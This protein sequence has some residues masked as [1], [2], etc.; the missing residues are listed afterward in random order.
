MQNVLC[1]CAIA[2]IWRRNALKGV[3]HPHRPVFDATVFEDGAHVYGC[4]SAP[5][6]GFDEV[7][8]YSILQNLLPLFFEVILVDDGSTDKTVELVSKSEM[9]ALRVIHNNE[10]LGKGYS[11]RRGVLAASGVYV[12]FADADLSAPIEEVTKLLDVAINDGAD[13]VIGSR[14]VDRRFIEKHQSWFREFGGV[15]FNLAVRALLGLNLRDTQCGF[16]LFHRQNT[17]R[18]FERLTTFGFGFDPEL[19]FLAKRAGLRIREVS[20]RWSHSEGS[21]F[22][23]IRNGSRMFADLVRIRWLAFTGRYP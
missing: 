13:V 20:V 1:I 11:V 2:G 16:K 4:A 18:A 23:P 9:L 21:R 12:L 6:A 17:R 22:D 14:N 5:H 19:L 8:R 3:R 15:A 7:A 10:N